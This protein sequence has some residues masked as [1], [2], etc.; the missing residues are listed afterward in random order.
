VPSAENILTLN[1][2]KR[3]WRM[4][5]MAMVVSYGNPSEIKEK[6]ESE[7]RVKA[8]L[9]E[10]RDGLCEEIINELDSIMQKV[11]AS[12]IELCPKDTGALASSINL[13]GGAISQGNDFYE[14]NIYAG[15]DDIINYKTG[16][17]TSEY[18]QYVEDGHGTYEG[19][20]FLEEAMMKYENELELAVNRALAELC[21]GD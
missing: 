11:L 5:K 6:F 4:K 17:A 21:T 7:E 10:I 2:K 15:S 8:Q 12:A 1:S 20:P 16:K 19:V 9:A 14:A 3:E 13:E 18:A